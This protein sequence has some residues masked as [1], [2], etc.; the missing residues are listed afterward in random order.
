M[1]V[2]VDVQNPP[3]L[4]YLDHPADYEIPDF[5]PIA[6]V[7]GLNCNDPIHELDN[8]ANCG[9]Y[10]LSFDVLLSAVA[11]DISNAY[12]VTRKNNSC[13]DSVLRV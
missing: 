2:S 1:L 5:W 9:V 11:R 8:S 6:F 7:Q 12:V 13:R 3:R 4:I 10:L